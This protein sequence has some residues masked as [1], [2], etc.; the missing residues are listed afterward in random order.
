MKFGMVAGGYGYNHVRRFFPR[1]QGW[2]KFGQV[3]GR[4]PRLARTVG[5]NIAFLPFSPNGVLLDFGSGNGQFMGFM[6]QLGWHAEGLEPD[7]RAREQA[8]QIGF[9]IWNNLEEVVSRKR[10]FHAIV[11]R[12]VIEHLPEPRQTL[13]TLISLLEPGGKLV[14]LSPNPNSFLLRVFGR[15][16]YPLHPPHHFC[17]V[18]PQAFRQFLGEAPGN[19]NVFCISRFSYWSIKEGFASAFPGKIIPEWLL[20]ASSSACRCFSAIA[21]SDG[22]EVVFVFTKSA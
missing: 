22:E 6:R 1:N 12:H 15:H 9:S 20:K 11:L 2:F 10:L 13:H 17:L 4:I 14:T 3:I 21:D 18:A 19:L 8:R 16:W 5:H 7:P